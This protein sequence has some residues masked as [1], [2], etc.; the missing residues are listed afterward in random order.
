MNWRRNQSLSSGYTSQVMLILASAEQQKICWHMDQVSPWLE[1][2][3]RN[4]KPCRTGARAEAIEKT[5]RQ[6][7]KCQNLI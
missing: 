3:E 6:T 4:W 1:C 7:N 5:G 2:T